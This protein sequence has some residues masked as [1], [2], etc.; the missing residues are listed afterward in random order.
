MRPNGVSSDL[1]CRPVAHAPDQPL[2]VGR[3]DLA[4]QAVAA[5][6]GDQQ[7]R[8]VER[9]PDPFVR[10][11][12]DRRRA[13]PRQ[14]PQDIELGPRHG[15]RVVG[16]DLVQ[17][18][19]GRVVPQARRRRLVEPHRYPGSQV[20][21]KTMHCAPCASASR[22]SA[23]ARST[24]RARLRKTGGCWTTASRQCCGGIPPCYSRSNMAAEV[25]YD[26]PGGRR[27]RCRRRRLEEHEARGVARD[28]H[29]ERPVRVRDVR[30]GEMADGSPSTRTRR[31][32]RPA[33]PWTPIARTPGTYRPRWCRAT[34]RRLL[35]RQI[36]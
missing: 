25:S 7:H 12:H 27:R 10:P 8:V 16:E 1:E 5:V 11:H 31:S 30:T 33:R 29:A 13:L 17:R 3:H 36:V 34:G 4:M 20:S 6:G 24:L 22:I 18:L 21:G 32:S 9:A 14:R 2:G 35:S 15:D 26:P 19:R 23:V 28:R